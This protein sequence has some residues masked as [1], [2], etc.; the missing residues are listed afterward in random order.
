M[1][2]NPIKRRSLKT[3]SMMKFSHNSKVNRLL[4][5][6][7]RVAVQAK[8]KAKVIR[9]PKLKRPFQKTLVTKSKHRHIRNLAVSTCWT[10]R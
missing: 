1:I 6:R 4:R 3:K 10:N 8:A 5:S 2:K 7:V 9:I